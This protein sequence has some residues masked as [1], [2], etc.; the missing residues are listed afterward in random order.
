MISGKV[1]KFGDL[2]S[3]DLML[4]QPAQLLSESEQ[5]KWIFQANRPDW[6]NQ[7]RKGDV[8]VAGKSFGTGSSRPAARSLRNAGVA[9][10]IADSL[11]R[12][13]FRNAANFGMLALECPGVSSAFEE[14]QI[15]EISVEDWKVCNGST[16]AV[17]EI[18]PIPDELLALMQ[19]GGIFPL[20]ER[21][22]ILG[23]PL[24][25]TGATG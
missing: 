3:T 21:E 2:I 13:F 10:V 9:C 1:W 19:S 25:Q 20:L 12:L 4:P 15:A 18:R 23:P 11:A 8:I 7:V 24:E 16:G 22:G 17:L 5:V 14:G 6:I